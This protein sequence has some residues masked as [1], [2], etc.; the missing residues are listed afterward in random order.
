M[1]IRKRFASRRPSRTGRRLLAALALAC[2]SHALAYDGVTFGVQVASPT[3][4]AVPLTANVVVPVAKVHDVRGTP[5][6]VAV[7]G[8]VSYAVGAGLGPSAGVNV[9]LSDG[10]DAQTHAKAYLGTGVAVANAGGP[11]LVPTAYALAGWRAPLGGILAVRLEGLVNV[12]L[13]SAALQLGVDL[14]PWGAR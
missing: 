5:V 1:S 2:A 13:R 10:S 8:D 14:S 3:H 12:T 6:G 9:L 4:G 7:R 11:V